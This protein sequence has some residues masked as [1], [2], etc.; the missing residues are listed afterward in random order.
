MGTPRGIR[1]ANPGNIERTG[2]KWQGMSADQSGDAR[3]IVFESPVW[4]IRA[5]AKILLN[6]Q[7]KYGLRHVQGII[8]RWAPP[9]ENDTGAYVRQVCRALGVGP[10]DTV[11]LQDTATLA[12]L[13]TAVIKHENGMQPYSPDLIARGVGMA[14]S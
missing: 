12:K 6:Y 11:N 3:F 2:E 5:M 10:T 14:L 1:N 4:G 9:T 13:V 7:R 8:N